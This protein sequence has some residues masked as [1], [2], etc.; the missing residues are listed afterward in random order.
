MK[1]TEEFLLKLLETQSV[2]GSEAGL[3]PVLDEFFAE[4]T[5]CMLRD[6]LGSAIYK[7]PEGLRAAAG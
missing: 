5:D 2:S 1:K 3:A 6:K 4:T 7:K